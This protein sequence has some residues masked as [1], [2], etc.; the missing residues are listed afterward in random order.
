MPSVSPEQ[1]RLMGMAYSLKKG[2]MD[3]KDASEQVKK[4]A[5][6][7]TLK[8]LKDFASTKHSDMKKEHA[9]TSYERFINEDYAR[10]HTNPGMN[11]GGMGPIV[12]PEVGDFNSTGSGDIPAPYSTR[13]KKLM[14]RG[15]KKGVMPIK[16][17]ETDFK[18]F[19]NLIQ[20]EACQKIMEKLSAA[21]N[22]TNP[23][24]VFEKAETYTRIL[25]KVMPINEDSETYY[26][27][28]ETRKNQ[29]DDFIWE[30][31]YEYTVS[32]NINEGFFSRIISAVKDGGKA[33]IEFA[34]KVIENVGAFLKA[35][36]EYIKTGLTAAIKAGVDASKAI[37]SKAKEKADALKSKID[38]TADTLKKDLKDLK[39]TV[40]HV[41]KGL[42][43]HFSTDNE[44]QAIS[45][46]KSAPK[47]DIASAERSLDKAAANESIFYSLLDT[48]MRN[49]I[50]E[51]KHSKDAIDSIMEDAES[52][53]KD[54]AADVEAKKK[55][56]AENKVEKAKGKGTSFMGIVHLL[57]TGIMTFVEA[58]LTALYQN[59]FKAVSAV[60]AALG[61]PGAFEFVAL[62]SLLAAITGLVLEL[63]A[64]VI[65]ELTGSKQLK[66]IS[67]V[68]HATNP[69]LLVA[70]AVEH[71][72]PG[73]SSIIKI[74][75][76][77][78]AIYA[79]VQHVAHIGGHGEDHGKEEP[80]KA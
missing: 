17:A 36:K 74:C 69:A 50:F 15:K 34:K 56:S 49:T 32:D 80:A 77:S 60:V 43:S 47:E 21:L 26:S 70:H 9:T 25:E 4:L 48:G 52:V 65:G 57:M 64:E 16:F 75:C 6:S 61:G 44:K 55:E 3:P 62:S 72:L 28:S 67:A 51:L 41:V 8:Q 42:P 30:S 23:H 39:D 1:Q 33:A 18:T 29:I 58:A 7:M 54:I 27:L 53:G 38:E 11:V 40:E 10:V 31:I 46:L 14:K 76:I 22:F 19:E 59:G 73:V 20:Y 24:Q 12:V 35:A 37:V 68:L 2:E 5:D 78:Y 71:S 45:I 66:A 79:T 63:F 13:D